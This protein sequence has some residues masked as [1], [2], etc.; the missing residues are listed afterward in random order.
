MENKF[1]RL[2]NSSNLE[3]SSRFENILMTNRRTPVIAGCGA[4]RSVRSGSGLSSPLASKPSF[5]RRSYSTGFFRAFSSV[6]IITERVLKIQRQMT[7]SNMPLSDYKALSVKPALKARMYAKSQTKHVGTTSVIGVGSIDPRFVRMKSPRSRQFLRRLDIGKHSKISALRT[8][9]LKTLLY[10]SEL[11]MGGGLYTTGRKFIRPTTGHLFAVE[12][13]SIVCSRKES[14]S[15]RAPSFLK[16]SAQK[17][18]KRL[19]FRRSIFS[20]SKFTKKYNKFN[21]KAFLKNSELTLR[22]EY[23]P[24]EQSS[25]SI[26]QFRKASQRLSPFYFTKSPTIPRGAI[27]LRPVVSRFLISRGLNSSIGRKILK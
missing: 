19:A 14:T 13:S 24:F 11:E 2:T 8:A 12:T 16:N 9:R 7:N 23:Q 18:V 26:L 5:F 25:R 10:P 21:R 15:R 6:P 1:K 17:N 27:V 3:N 4:A 20:S 22:A